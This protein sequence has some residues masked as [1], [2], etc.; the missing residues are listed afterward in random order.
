MIVIDSGS[1]TVTRGHA[2]LDV[3]SEEWGQPPASHQAAEI[4]AD[5]RVEERPEHGSIYVAAGPV[6]ELPDRQLEIEFAAW[7]AASDEALLRF[8]AGLD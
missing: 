6:E 1:E 5:L 4:L 8:E 2:L 7:D 3:R